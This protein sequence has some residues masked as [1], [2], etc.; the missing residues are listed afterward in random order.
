MPVRAVVLAA[1]QARRDRLVNALVVSVSNH[2]LSA[3]VVR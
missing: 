3:K 1:R 2:E